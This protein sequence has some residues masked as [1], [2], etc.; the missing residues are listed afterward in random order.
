MQAASKYYFPKGRMVIRQS[1]KG[2]W[3]LILWYKN[4]RGRGRWLAAGP[5]VVDTPEYA[6][7]IYTSF[8][9]RNQLG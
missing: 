1:E 7:E 8:D 9:E 2:E 4:N 5:G 6:R 3:S